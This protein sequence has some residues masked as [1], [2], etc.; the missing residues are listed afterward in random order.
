MTCQLCT[1]RVGPYLYGVDVLDVQE[2]ISYQAMAPVPLAP[3]ELRGLINLRGQIVTAIDLRRRLGFDDADGA[4]P[5]NVVVRTGST[6]VSFLVD[7]IGD[8]VEV[9]DSQRE[10]VPDTVGRHARGL[11]TAV[12]KFEHELL[13]VLDAQRT[14]SVSVLETG[15]A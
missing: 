9:D 15:A 8:V 12:Y 1:F 4:E 10:P 5:M 13:H 14:A 7:S 6:A 11:I 3:P 2:A